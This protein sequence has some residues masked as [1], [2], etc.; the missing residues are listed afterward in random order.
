DQTGPIPGSYEVLKAKE[1]RYDDPR[2][3]YLAAD[4]A[5]PSNSSSSWLLGGDVRWTDYE[6]LAPYADCDVD[7]NDSTIVDQHNRYPGL[8]GEQTID[9]T[10]TPTA[11]TY[12]DE[13]LI[14]ST[15]QTTNV[16]GAG[17]SAVSYTAFGERVGSFT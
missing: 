9:D 15:M 5:T 16:A 4:V 6:A 2:A 1:F 3:L 8:A 11:N 13:D 10:G 14:G 12:W 17:G 7:P